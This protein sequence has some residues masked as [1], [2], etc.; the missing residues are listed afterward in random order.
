MLCLNLKDIFNVI[1]PHVAQL[2]TKLNKA[3][4]LLGRFSYS[5]ILSKNA[6]NFT[7]QGLI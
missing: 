6:Y 2:L 3:V 4:A 7:Q 5:I 1:L